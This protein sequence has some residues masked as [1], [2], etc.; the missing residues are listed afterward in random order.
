MSSRRKEQE[1]RKRN[2]SYWAEHA[3]TKQQLESELGKLQIELKELNVQLAPFE[4]ELKALKDKRVDKVPA[5]KVKDTVLAEISRLR[6]EQE[7]L[8]IFK[9]KE[10]KALQTQIDELNGRLSTIDESIESER[11]EQQSE[12][13]AKIRDVDERAMPIIDKI[14]STQKRIDEIKAV[15]TKNR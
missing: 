13:N 6:K 4:K 8:G 12:Y 3:E 2:E 11:K 7:Q 9:G 1:Q 15:L 14:A 5:E 10:K